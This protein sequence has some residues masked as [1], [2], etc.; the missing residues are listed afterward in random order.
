MKE[1][2]QELYTLF[3]GYLHQ[4]WE[5]QYV[6]EENEDVHFKAAIEAYKEDS[7]S[8]HIEKTI[9]QLKALINKNYTDNILEEIMIYQLS[10]FID[11]QGFG[12]SNKS[13]LIEVLKLLEE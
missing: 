11:P 10:T 2:N 13:F 5:D 7:S 8:E 12:F 1:K 6:W 3:A 4:G 9:K